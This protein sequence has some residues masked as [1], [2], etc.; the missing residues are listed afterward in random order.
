MNKIILVLIVFLLSFSCKR[1]NPIYKV[2]DIVCVK[3]DGRK[4]SIFYVN[5][6]QN[7]A[8]YLVTFVNEKN[9]NTKIAIGGSTGIG[10][11][12]DGIINN[13]PYIRLSLREPELCDCENINDKK[14]YN[15]LKRQHK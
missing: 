10:R 14:L 11:A 2:G 8:L 9:S 13:K 5:D 12:G 6:E 3:L 7:P 1:S 4:G 15:F